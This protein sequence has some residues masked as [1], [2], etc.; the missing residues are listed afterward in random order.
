MVS[1]QKDDGLFPGG[2]PGRTRALL[3]EGPVAMFQK[4][5]F[6]RGINMNR[7]FMV[8]LSVLFL[9]FLASA[10]QA[11]WDPDL[12][13]KAREAVAEFKK[14]D[15]S[16]KS[17]F[18][19]AYGYAVFPTVAKGAMGVGAARGAG[20]VFQRGKAIGK[21]TLTQVT[22]GFQFGGQAYREIIFFEDKKTLDNFKSGN[23]ELAAQASAVAATAGASA[24][25]S[26]KNGLA[27]FTMAKGGLMYEASI[28]GQKFSYEPL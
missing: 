22:I 17:F 15:P 24:N 16:M 13:K 7:L 4:V 1:V 20:M 11:R 9:A 19:K 3:E 10:A 2:E 8:G 14:A 5:V 18:D 25:A 6:L 27:V 28:G 26:Y 12:E 23:F 21:T